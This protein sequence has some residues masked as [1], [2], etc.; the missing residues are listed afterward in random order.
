MIYTRGIGDWERSEK[1]S[2]LEGT[3]AWTGLE[4]AQVKRILICNLKLAVMA[5]KDPAMQLPSNERLE[6]PRG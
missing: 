4:L 1:R 2:K 3:D 5:M 6:W